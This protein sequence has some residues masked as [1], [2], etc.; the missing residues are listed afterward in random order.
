LLKRTRADEESATVL[1]DEF[2]DAGL[3]LHTFG[4]V[5]NNDEIVIATCR[6]TEKSFDQIALLMNAD[7]K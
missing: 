1:S 6:L 4:A 2:F 3:L 5:V 7:D